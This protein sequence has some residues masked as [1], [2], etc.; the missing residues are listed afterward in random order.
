M[1]QTDLHEVARL[2]NDIHIDYPE[3]K[4]VF[5]NRFH[6]YPAGCSVLDDDGM[7]AGYAITH[8]WKRYHPARL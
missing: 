6:L 1:R 5:V 4:A 3:D 2:A 8:P 7:L